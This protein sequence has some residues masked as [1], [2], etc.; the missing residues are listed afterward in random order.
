MQEQALYIATY[1]LQYTLPGWNGIGND[2][3]CL[4]LSQ[5]FPL[6]KRLCRRFPLINVALSPISLKATSIA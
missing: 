4:S 1:P 3:I 6:S 2:P 5:I